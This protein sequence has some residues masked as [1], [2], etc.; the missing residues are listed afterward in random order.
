M[1]DEQA[2]PTIQSEPGTAT[3]NPI[4]GQISKYQMRTA[5]LYIIAFLNRFSVT[6]HL[7]VIATK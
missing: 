2:W 3:C 5:E 7:H 1:S 4:N 6:S